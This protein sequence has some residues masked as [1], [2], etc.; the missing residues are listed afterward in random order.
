VLEGWAKERDVDLDVVPCDDGIGCDQQRILE[1]IDESTLVVALSHAE[2]KSAYVNDAQAIAQRC[3]EVGARLLLDTFQSAGV[4]EIEARKWGVDAVVGGCLKW[5]CGGPGNVYL[6]VDPGLAP[7]LE[8]TITGWMAHPAPFA[9]EDAP[10]RWRDDAYRFLN[11]TPQIACLY[12]AG[13]GLDLHNGIGVKAI[14]EK[15]KRMTAMLFD[16]AK[17]RGWRVTAPEDPEVRGGTVAVDVAHG[18]L[19]AKELNARDVVVDYR[20]G[21]GIRL[22]PHFYNSLDECTYAL[23]QIA[24]ILESRAFE[25]HDSVAGATPT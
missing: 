5:L 12:A 22:A 21:A 14:R 3:R 18:E 17:E 15:S 8:P 24:E 4:V 1:A 13:P 23:D 10:M 6:Y 2:F 11:G 16:G 7:D 25:K 20:P 9:F 19:V